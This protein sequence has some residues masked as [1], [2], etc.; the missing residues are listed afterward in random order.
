[1]YR[2]KTLVRKHTYGRV[3]GNK[4][5]AKSKSIGKDVPN[6]LMSTDKVKLFK[7]ITDVRMNYSTR[8]SLSQVW[9]AKKIAKEMVEMQQGSTPCSC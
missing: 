2:T 9:K 4:N 7:I 6:K 1:M 8:I 3:F 5:I